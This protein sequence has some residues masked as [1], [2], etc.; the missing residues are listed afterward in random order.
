MKKCSPQPEQWSPECGCR[1][2]QHHLRCCWVHTVS[3]SAP[4]LGESSPGGREL[5]GRAWSL[6]F[7]RTSSLGTT[8]RGLG[9]VAK[10][11]CFYCLLIVV[12]IFENSPSS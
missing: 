10:P 4:P 9:C 6:R 12:L 2:Q 11:L 7:R 8:D 3:G 1:R 5:T